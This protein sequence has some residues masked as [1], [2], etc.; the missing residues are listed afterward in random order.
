VIETVPPIDRY[1]LVNGGATC[2]RTRWLAY[3]GL[4]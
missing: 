3:A 4:G 2:N 1:V